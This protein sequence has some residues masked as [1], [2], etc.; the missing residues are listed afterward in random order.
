MRDDPGPEGDGYAAERGRQEQKVSI[1]PRFAQA[2]AFP[3]HD[4]QGQPRIRKFAEL[5]EEIAENRDL[6]VVVEAAKKASRRI[7]G[8]A[9]PEQHKAAVHVIAD[10]LFQPRGAGF[11]PQHPTDI[12]AQARKGGRALIAVCLAAC[13]ERG[14]CHSCAAFYP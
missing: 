2:A 11:H 1:A 13:A 14:G 10:L 8:L 9:F 6:D 12:T 7:N 4:A 3:A 5:D